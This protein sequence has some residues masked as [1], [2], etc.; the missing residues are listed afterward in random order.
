MRAYK[1]ATIGNIISWS[2]SIFP[3]KETKG[4]RHCSEKPNRLSNL[5]ILTGKKGKGKEEK[6]GEKKE[7]RKGRRG[8]KKRRKGKEEGKEGRKEE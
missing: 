2:W 1:Q 8:E 7:G 6:E 5:N 3:K 4:N